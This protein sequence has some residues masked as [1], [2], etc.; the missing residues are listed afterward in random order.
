MKAMPQWPPQS[1]APEVIQTHAG[2]YA[3]MGDP[4]EIGRA[5]KETRRCVAR[6]VPYARDLAHNGAT[7]RP[8]PPDISSWLQD[9][10]RG[11]S[12]MLDLIHANREQC[13]AL[14]AAREKALAQSLQKQG[15]MHYAH[16]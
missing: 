11:L 6:M 12:M 14:V 7:R 15:Q 3:N 10:D 2:A 16:H 4:F 13:R 1:A 8:A 9:P 5:I